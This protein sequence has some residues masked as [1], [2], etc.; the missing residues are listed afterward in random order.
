MMKEINHGVIMATRGEAIMPKIDFKKLPEALNLA[1][2]IR[3]VEFVTVKICSGGI[4]LAEELMEAGVQNISAKN[5][6]F[7]NKFKM[8]D[9]QEAR[10][11]KLLEFG[12]S[13]QMTYHP[14]VYWNVALTH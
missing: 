9:A 6:E 4:D 3:I 8:I 2:M 11:T 13:M 14:M 10:L 12:L 5:P 1:N 7:A